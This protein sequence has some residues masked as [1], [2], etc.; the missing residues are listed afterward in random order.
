MC[1]LKAL[2]LLATL[3]AFPTELTAQVVQRPPQQQQQRP[4]PSDTIPVPPFRFEPPVSPFGAFARSALLPGWGQAV[5]GRR[6]TGVFFVFWEGLSLTMTVKSVRQLHYQ[7]SIGVHPDSL[8]NKRAEVEDWFVILV[9][10][11][12][13]AGAE[14][15][16]SAH[17]WDFPAELA[18]KALPGGS[19]GV[20]LSFRLGGSAVPTRRRSG[21]RVRPR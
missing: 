2:L 19:V 6:G 18:A 8:D 4:D 9:F 15:F 13:V 21:V 14:A 3:V 1:R 11:H 7:E 20:G 5:L 17:L 16:V 10:N 12:L